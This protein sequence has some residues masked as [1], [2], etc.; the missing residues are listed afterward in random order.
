MLPQELF[1][2]ITM[3]DI[4]FAAG[5]V[6]AL[7]TFRLMSDKLGMSAKMLNFVL[8][9]GVAAILAGAISAVLFQAIYNYQ[10]TGVFELTKNTGMTF[11]GGF[12]GGAVTFL[13]IYFGV[14][15]IA[16]RDGENLREL[17]R[18]TS[19]GACCVAIAHC[20]G[21]IGCLCAGCCHGIH[22]ESPLGWFMPGVEDTV[23]PTQ[24]YEAIFLALMFALL[25]W[26]TLRRGRYV[27]PIYLAAYGAWRFALEY[28]R[29]DDRG[30]SLVSWLTPSQLTAVCL[31][32]CSVA[33]FFIERRFSGVKMSASAD[34][35]GGDSD[36]GVNN[37][38]D[39]DSEKA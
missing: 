34:N 15:R 21:R 39:S 6:S 4:L 33:L 8:A 37:G 27:L 7:V 14:G 26:R 29:G 16:F 13:A 22:A 1:F 38:G 24:L 30:S 25:V 31:I 36:S 5:I 9:D 3:Y 32:A 35:C 17:F 10:K 11:Y 28:F 2:G 19:I 12:I 23:L 18:V 20:I